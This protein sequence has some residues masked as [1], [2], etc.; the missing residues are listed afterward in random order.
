MVTL[1]IKQPILIVAAMPRE[2]ES[3]NFIPEIQISKPPLLARAGHINNKKIIMASTGVGKT[4]SINNISFLI[5]TFNPGLVINVG[6]AGGAHPDIGAG[7]VVIANSVFS[8]EGT[9]IAINP[10]LVDIASK[11]AR[12]SKIRFKKAPI[13]TVPKFISEPTKKAMW[14][15]KHKAFALDMESYFIAKTCVQKDIPFLSIRAISDPL[16]FP[17]PNI[18]LIREDGSVVLTNMIKSFFRSPITLLKLASYEK[19]SNHNINSLVQNV[20][21]LL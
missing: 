12:D 21:M 11:C 14:G 10:A 3:F 17:L 9:K 6:Y 16:S 2:L 1:E 5:K 18:Q 8:P 20:I 4:C 19:S 15:T 7:D 13:V